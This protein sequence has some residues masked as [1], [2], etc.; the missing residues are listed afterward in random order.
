MTHELVLRWAG[1][2][3]NLMGWNDGPRG[4]FRIQALPK[5]TDWGNPEPVR[6]V[7]RRFL[8]DGSASV[9]EY[10]DNRTIQL[11]L[12]LSAPDGDA[13]A[14]GEIPLALADSLRCELVWTPK[15]SR[16]AAVVYVATSIDL[17]HRNAADAG[18][19]LGEDRGR[20][21]Y[22]L[23][24]SCLPHAYADQW[25][26]IH[27]VPQGVSTPTLVDDCTSVANWSAINADLSVVDG[28]IVV[29]TAS[30][31][32]YPVIPGLHFNVKRTGTIDLSTRPYLAIEWIGNWYTQPTL[33]VLV[34]GQWITVP[35]SGTDGTRALFRVGDA[36]ASID[37]F[38]I[39][40]FKP[41]GIQAANNPRIEA[42]YTQATPRSSESKQQIRAIEVP[43]SRRTP[44]T[45]H[46]E[47][48]VEALGTTIVYAGPDYDPSLSWATVSPA[49]TPDAA[50]LSGSIHYTP[51]VSATYTYQRSAANMPPG[52]Y[53]IWAMLR[54]FGGTGGTLAITRELTGTPTAVTIGT[55]TLSPMDD[56]MLVPLMA[57]DLP[58]DRLPPG[59]GAFIT[60]KLI[61]AGSDGSELSVDEVLLCN[62][63][64][65]SFI[66]VEAGSALSLWLDPPTLEND[67]AA[68]YMAGSSQKSAAR[69][70][71]L[72]SEVK[73]GSAAISLTPPLSHIY[74]GT[75]GTADAVLSGRIRP[76]HHT[77]TTS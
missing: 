72:A 73:S 61:W 12:R 27:P 3:L 2:E 17:D 56:Y 13:L 34:A 66:V 26:D 42:V 6:R 46:I 32:F 18:D 51:G 40:A 15:D 57:A 11:S 5:G 58:G 54:V 71:S 37:A 28:R 59:S 64:E 31:E 36:A 69:A 8:A 63:T 70:A 74:V 22:T 1:G 35:M 53:V 33:Q 62:V 23:R 49:R 29:A 44:A 48:E 41:W 43:G 76:A 14:G 47:S 55:V 19:P 16:A 75:S 20:R 39:E 52:G 67:T 4:Q 50:R 7:L 68:I 30:T 45:L 38:H 24:L 10:D 60:I 65:G 25:I 77:H 21:Y 9:K